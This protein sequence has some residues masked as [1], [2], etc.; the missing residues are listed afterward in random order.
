MAVKKI[1]K[2]VMEALRGRIVDCHIPLPDH[3]SVEIVYD[4]HYNAYKC[5]FY[6]G[7]SLGDPFTL[8]FETKSYFE[9]L[10]LLAFTA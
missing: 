7:A 6:P 1:H 9:V 3:F 8:R 5:S 10:R 4:S 2:G